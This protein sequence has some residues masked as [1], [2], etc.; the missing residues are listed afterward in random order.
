MM[1]MQTTEA[2][3]NLHPVAVINW[4]QWKVLGPAR[5]SLRSFQKVCRSSGSYYQAAREGGADR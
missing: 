5:A 3:K 2:S 4:D 1:K